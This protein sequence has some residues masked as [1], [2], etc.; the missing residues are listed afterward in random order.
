MKCIFT[1]NTKN[2]SL[3]ISLIV[4]LWLICMVIKTIS[5]CCLLTPRL[6]YFK[7]IYQPRWLFCNIYLNALSKKEYIVTI[8][9]LTTIVPVK[10]WKWIKCKYMSVNFLR[11][12]RV[13][14]SKYILYSLWFEHILIKTIQ[15]GME[16]RLCLCYN[17]SSFVF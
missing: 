5:K 10:F 14:R 9:V 1:T 15:L 8:I 11:L 4:C 16:N 2:K 12:W 17:S 3:Q 7:H 6:L 13:T